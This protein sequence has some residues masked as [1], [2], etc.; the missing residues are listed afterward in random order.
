[1]RPL[2]AAEPMLRAPRPEMTPASKRGAFASFAARRLAAEAQPWRRAATRGLAD[3]RIMLVLRA[4]WPAR[5]RRREREQAVVD[6]DVGLGVIDLD[7]R[8]AAVGLAL[9][10]VENGK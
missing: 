3:R 10:D 7:L 1:M 2:I 9:G 4:P 8:A 6:R 5:L